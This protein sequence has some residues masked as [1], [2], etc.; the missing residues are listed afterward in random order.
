MQNDK[1]KEKTIEAYR[2]K[3]NN[4]EKNALVWGTYGCKKKTKGLI[5]ISYGRTCRRG[6]S[7]TRGSGIDIIQKNT[8]QLEL[9]D[10][11]DISDETQR[12]IPEEPYTYKEYYNGVTNTAQWSK[13]KYRKMPFIST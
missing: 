4:N 8:T 10:N 2:A 13:Q 5:G 12:N 11:N 9:T 6:N 7:N 1:D 3:R